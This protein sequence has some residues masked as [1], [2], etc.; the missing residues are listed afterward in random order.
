MR[1]PRDV[2]GHELANILR[3]YGY[4]VARQSGSHVQLETTILGTSHI[5]TVP[6]HRS[7]KV[8]TLNS[9]LSRVANYLKID[10]SELIKELFEK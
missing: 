1:L 3:R 8:G 2:S 10:R 4:Q 9:I 6:A 5:V 7:L